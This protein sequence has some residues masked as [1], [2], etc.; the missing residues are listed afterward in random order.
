[1][2]CGR[3]N[4]VCA[5]VNTGPPDLLPDEPPAPNG[6]TGYMGLLGHK[7]VAPQISTSL[8]MTD[9]FGNTIQDPNG[10][11]GFPGFDGMS[12]AV[13]LSYVAG[14]QEHGVPITYAYISAAHDKHPFAPAYCPGQSGYDAAL[15]SYEAPF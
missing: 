12:A 15:P 6:Y 13:S 7:Y 1:M 2:N 8:P 5:S 3:G 11:K 10:N 9:L 4:A 14:M